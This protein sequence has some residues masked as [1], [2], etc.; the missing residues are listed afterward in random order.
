LLENGTG[1]DIVWVTRDELGELGDLREENAELKKQSQWISAG[2]ELPE[3][4]DYVLITDSAGFTVVGYFWP[5]DSSTYRNKGA[6]YYGD[7]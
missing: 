2:D 4:D 3:N 7:H 6:W 5:F 1:K